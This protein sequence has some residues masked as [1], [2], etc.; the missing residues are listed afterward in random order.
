MTRARVADRAKQPRTVHL[1]LHDRD[2]IQLLVTR[3]DI[4]TANA[5]LRLVHAAHGVRPPG[6]LTPPTPSPLSSGA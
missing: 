6:T 3:I 1:Q 5:I 4:A 2:G